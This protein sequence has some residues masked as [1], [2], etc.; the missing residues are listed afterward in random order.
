MRVRTHPGEVL[1]EEFLKP[2]KLSA[3][4]LGRELGVPAN[5]ISEIVNG[6]RALTADTAL[7]LGRYFRTTPQFWLN[8]QMAYDLSLA[9]EARGRQIKT[10][11]RPREMRRAS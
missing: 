6:S 1:A 7:R 9:E 2:L 5:R 11:V 10:K 3:N 4:A 8:L